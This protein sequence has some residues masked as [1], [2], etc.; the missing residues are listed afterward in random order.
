MSTCISAS[1]GDLLCFPT[2]FLIKFQTKIRCEDNII[3][4]EI[5]CYQPKGTVCVCFVSS[6]L[7]VAWDVWQYGGYN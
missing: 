6:L 4:V 7:Q 3:L 5:N 2:F 1:E